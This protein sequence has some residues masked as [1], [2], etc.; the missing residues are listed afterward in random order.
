MKI[1]RNCEGCKYIGIDR[2]C[3][4]CPNNKKRFEDACAKIEI[5]KSKQPKYRN[6]VFERNGE[7]YRSEKEF[8]RHMILKSWVGIKSISNLQREVVYELIPSVIL[9]GRKK[10][11]IRY[12]LDFEY[13]QN[14]KLIAEDTKSPITKKNPVYR[15]KA[16]LMKHVYNIDIRE[17]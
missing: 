16:H 8:N 9:N 2:V 6:R 11:P 12:I 14:G 15:L 10:P 5:K 13:Y 17:V 1:K 3:S 7:K 4:K